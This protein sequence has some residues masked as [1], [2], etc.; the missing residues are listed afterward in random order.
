EAN[1]G[2]TDNY[3]CR[4]RALIADWRQQF[5]RAG[6]TS[7]TFPFLFVQLSPYHG[8]KVDGF[9][10]FPCA[11][12]GGSTHGSLAA[13]RLVQLEALRLEKVG[14][15]S[16]VDLGDAASP[17]WPGSVHPR[18][19]QPVGARLALEARRLAYGEAGLV[20]RGPQIEHVEMLPSDS[21]TGSYHSK[22]VRI[23]RL[24]WTS[25][26]SGLQVALGAYS[27]V[28]FI[29]TLNNTK[30]VP[31]AIMPTNLTKY[32][33]DVYFNL[34]YNSSSAAGGCAP[35]VTAISYLPFDFPIVPLFNGEG[36]P[37]EPFMFNFTNFADLSKPQEP[38]DYWNPSLVSAD[39][40][41]QLP[42]RTTSKETS[43]LLESEGGSGI[44]I[45]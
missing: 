32:T 10:G 36:F 25:V 41:T 19:K 31:G 13:Q 26:G 17:Y 23:V 20:S 21:T 28:A 38:F 42:V 15:A 35:F 9:G 3:G 5:S 40:S 2:T 29:A 18:H 30:T 43:L 7:A 37:A 27:S 8:D 6:R 1:L 44:H 24:H 39:G 14:M 11:V 45:K 12:E 16:A 4:F 22:N 34:G 33:C